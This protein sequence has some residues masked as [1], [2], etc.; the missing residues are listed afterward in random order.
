MNE[1]DLTFEIFR[2]FGP[3]IFK[4]RIPDTMI[5]KMNNYSEEIIKDK[6]KGKQ[7]SHGDSLAGNVTQEFSLDESFVKDS[8]WLNLLNIVSNHALKAMTGQEIKKITVNATWI[9]RQF[10]YE[11][12]PLHSHTGN[13]S[14]VAYL[15]VPKNLGD[16]V[17]KKNPTRNKNG[18]IIFVHGSTQFLSKALIGFTPAVGDFYLF[19][20]YLLHLVYPYYDTQE[21]RRSVSFNANLILK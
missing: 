21:E 17:K 20:S 16:T 1:D 2:P 11:Y 18:K 13:I 5:N 15:K 10:Q 6:D 8:G 7:L 14:G 4:T 3:P 9:V 19:P 12:N